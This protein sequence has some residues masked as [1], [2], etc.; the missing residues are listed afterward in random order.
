[1]KVFK[2]ETIGDAYMVA[3]G[4]EPNQE[5]H[6]ERMLTLAVRMIAAT[7]KILTSDGRSVQIRVGVHSGPVVAGVVGAKNQRY[8]F[9]G[10]TVNVASRMESHGV[11]SQVHISGSTYNMMKDRSNFNFISRGD[12]N[13]KG[14]GPMKTYIA[15]Q[16]DEVPILPDPTVVKKADPNI[17]SEKQYEEYKDLQNK[18]SKLLDKVQDLNSEIKSLEEAKTGTDKELQ[19][20]VEKISN[21]QQK[22]SQAETELKKSEESLGQLTKL[23]A[24]AV[25]SKEALEDK[26]QELTKECILNR[27]QLVD[28]KMEMAKRENGAKILP[29]TIANVVQSS[30]IDVDIA[31]DS[32]V[33]NLK[34]KILQTEEALRNKERLVHTLRKRCQE[35]AL[36]GLS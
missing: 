14:K 19:D 32:I 13:V 28:A 23:H 25:N 20:K 31:K 1:M 9:F 12:I 34:T 16:G 4:H 17:Y 35:L 5:D 30:T 6:C 18:S 21:L 10:D 22:L 24:T 2:V 29:E 8:C 7:S 26:I 15:Y 3:C 33:E 36:I 27:Q 11:P